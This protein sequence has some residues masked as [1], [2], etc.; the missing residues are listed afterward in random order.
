MKKIEFK[1]VGEFAKNV[2]NKIG[3]KN[4]AVAL[5]ILVIGAAVFAN[6][7][8]FS[9]PVDAIG[10]GTGNMSD[11][12]GSAD[13]SGASAEDISEE[14]SYFSTTVL[15]RQKARDEAL[16]V[17]QTVVA[18]AE[19]LDDTKAQ[20]FADISQIAKDIENEANIETLVE[21]KGFADCVAVVSGNTVN[22]VVKT[23]GLM[24]NDVA[25]INEIVYEQAGILPVNV[26]IVE[27]Q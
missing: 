9:D 6:Y 24:Q 2:Y 22:I 12:Y 1:K 11:T 27:R 14:D 25:Q 5:A 4:I 17:L 13:L 26:K 19:A 3:K 16:E 8:L 23:D 10:Y 7:M 18:S 15:S 21:A 20:A